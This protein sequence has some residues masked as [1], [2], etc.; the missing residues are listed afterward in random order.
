MK[1]VV[2]G[3]LTLVLLGSCAKDQTD[4]K[5]FDPA[6]MDLSVRPGDDFYKYVNGNWQKNNPVP[7]AY[8]EWGSFTIL[9]D[10][11]LQKLKSIM[12]EAA[13]QTDAEKGSNVQKIGDFYASG[14]DTNKINSEGVRGL[15]EELDLINNIKTKQDIEAVIA[16]LH[17]YGIGP[18]FS[19]FKEQ[20]PQKSDMVTIWLY[21]VVTDCR[22]AI[23]IYR[24]TDARK[25]LGQRIPN[26]L[27]I[28][29]N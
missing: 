17:Q 8:S 4:V 27:P 16:R 15:Q 1:R 22:I 20:D 25:R 14:M 13:A 2:F 7:P 23:I 12:E 19:I 26:T 18:L 28:C 11:N 24:M 10:E 21:Q 5:A 3:L 29:L 9:F 6:G